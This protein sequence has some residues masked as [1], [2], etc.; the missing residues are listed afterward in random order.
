MVTADISVP[1]GQVPQ[2]AIGTNLLLMDGSGNA[3]FPHN[4]VLELTQVFTLTDRYEITQPV[5]IYVNVGTYISITLSRNMSSTTASGSI[6]LSGHLIIFNL[7]QN[8]VS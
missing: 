3:F 5:R 7:E 8:P 2:L 6:T 4:I 1:N